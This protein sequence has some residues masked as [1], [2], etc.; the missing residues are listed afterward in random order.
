MGMEMNKSKM[1][2]NSAVWLQTIFR[3]GHGGNLGGEMKWP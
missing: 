3:D 1:K 2:I